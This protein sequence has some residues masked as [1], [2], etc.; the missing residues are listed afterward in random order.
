MKKLVSTI[1]VLL[2]LSMAFAG[3][4][5]FLGVPFGS[6]S[7]EAQNI[8]AEK[9]FAY[10]P[11]NQGFENITEIYFYKKD[12]TYLKKETGNLVRLKFLNDKLA[13]TEIMILL[14]SYDKETE[15]KDIISI[16]N[17]L[18]FELINI[19]KASDYYDDYILKNND[20]IVILSV[21]KSKTTIYLSVA[22]QEFL[23]A[24]KKAREK[25]LEEEKQKAFQD[26]INDM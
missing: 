12:L 4:F 6:S 26:A 1:F 25:K 23:D 11:Q 8:L 14:S 16:Y 18:D 13:Y 2:S 22:T 10:S 20:I 21:T 5:K 15:L 19:D 24:E 7:K 17:S 9:K 3:E